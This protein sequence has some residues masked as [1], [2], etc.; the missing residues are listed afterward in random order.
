M[1]I[2]SFSSFSL[3][4]ARSVLAAYFWHLCEIVALE[5]GPVALCKG[6]TDE[7]LLKNARSMCKLTIAFL[8]F[9][10]KTEHYCS[11]PSAFSIGVYIQNPLFQLDF[12]KDLWIQLLSFS[13]S[14]LKRVQLMIVG[15]CG[16]YLREVLRLLTHFS[17][18]SDF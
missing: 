18:C 7:R 14:T 4:Y 1:E 3:R 13:N 15:W 8:C 16:E 9:P 2:Y 11:F 10:C 17:C 6:E 12:T 5:K